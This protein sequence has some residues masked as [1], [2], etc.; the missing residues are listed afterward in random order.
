MISMTMDLTELHAAAREFP[1]AAASTLNRV[2]RSFRSEMSRQVRSIY[3]IKKGDLDPFI[4][5]P[6]RASATLLVTRISLSRKR[7]SLP[8]FGAKQT[9]A[10]A[11]VAVRRG[12]R[13]TVKGGF[14]SQ[15]KSG[16]IGVYRRT[17]PARLPIREVLGPTIAQMVA[18]RGVRPAL[19]N[20]LRERIPLELARNIAY[21]KR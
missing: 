2:G 15:M 11:R 20:F 17:G 7:V 12:S 19:D 3:S 21:L 14:V 6:S 16:H 1:R 8:K 9:Q 10:G 13:S 18:S 5:S 4:G